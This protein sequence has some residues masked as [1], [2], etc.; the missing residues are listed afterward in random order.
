MSL[1]GRVAIVTGAAQGIGRAYALAL[2]DDGAAVVVADLKQD[3]AQET[4]RLIEAAGG[5]GAAVPVDVSDPD[6]R[7]PWARRSRPAS[8]PLTSW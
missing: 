8:E 1:E 3:A 4:V 2:A 6:R 7:W 5:T